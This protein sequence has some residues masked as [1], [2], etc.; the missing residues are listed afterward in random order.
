MDEVKIEVQMRAQSLKARKFAYTYL[1]Y[2][3]YLWY[4]LQHKYHPETFRHMGAQY[5][6]SVINT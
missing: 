4:E 1:I 5:Q 6:E 2:L 3:W